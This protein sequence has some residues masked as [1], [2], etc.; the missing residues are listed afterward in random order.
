MATAGHTSNRLL[1]PI[2]FLHLW[3]FRRERYSYYVCE[4]SFLNGCILPLY[5]FCFIQCRV[6]C[7][8]ALISFSS[9]ITSYSSA[10]I[11]QNHN[12]NLQFNSTFSLNADPKNYLLRLLLSIDHPVDVI[13]ITIGNRNKTLINEIMIE[14]E[15]ARKSIKKN[16]KVCL[17]LMMFKSH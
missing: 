3:G 10:S 17:R 12:T 16:H 4:V 6:V 9:S 2:V 7:W 5:C 13:C 11:A 15:I 14:T 8:K 1:Q